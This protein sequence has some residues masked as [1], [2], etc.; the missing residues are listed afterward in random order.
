MLLTA[1]ALS[2]T[3]QFD[4]PPGI[5]TRQQLLTTPEG[6]QGLSRDPEGKPGQTL[7]HRLANLALFDGEPGELVQLKPDNGDSDEI[8]Y[9]SLLGSSL[10][11][12]YLVCHYQDTALTL[13]QALPLG[14]S[15]CRVNQGDPYDLR[16]LICR[17]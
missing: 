15:Y 7:S 17:K 5:E 6:W 1:L 8:H 4:C 13:Q 14:I 16:G 12:L 10:R 9:W 3:L 11:P 2:A